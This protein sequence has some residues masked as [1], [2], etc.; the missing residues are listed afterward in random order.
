MPAS[1]GRAAPDRIAL[2]L[3]TV[4]GLAEAIEAGIGIGPLP[5]MQ[6]D[7][8]PSL[9]RLTEPEPELASTLW[10]LTHPDLRHA[11]RV[12]AF[13]D[14][15]GDEMSARRALFEGRVAPEAT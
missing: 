11:P 15:V 13:M 8:C 7:L 12:R 14:F 3:N 1:C 6:G 10:L 5:C 4:L 9:M 2:Q